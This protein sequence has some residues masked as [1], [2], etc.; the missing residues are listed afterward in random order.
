M[1][2]QVKSVP[3]IDDVK[4]EFLELPEC[5]DTSH[6][7]EYYIQEIARL[8][9]QVKRLERQQDDSTKLM[10]MFSPVIKLSNLLNERKV[11]QPKVVMLHRPSIKKKRKAKN[12]LNTFVNCSNIESVLIKKEEP[13]DDPLE[14]NDENMITS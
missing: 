2:E 8:K 13:E 11:L 14:N 10:K 7:V 9:A 4:N 12:D 5:L 3:S 6:E 1:I